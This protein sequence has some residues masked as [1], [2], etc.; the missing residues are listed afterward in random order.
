[1]N[2]RTLV[3]GASTNPERYSYKAI[4]ALRKHN[5]D[6]IAFGIK[7][8]K[9]VDVD[10]IT[11]FPGDEVLDTVTLYVGPKNQPEYYDN[12]IKLKPKR[13]V[14]NPGTENDEFYD[15]LATHD[16]ESLEACTLVLLA[17]DQY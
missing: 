7:A 15:L 13:V 2:K 8:G 14:F 9:V 5:H 1:M 17:T 12:I 6:V 16:I 11:T 10:F 4:I 3:L